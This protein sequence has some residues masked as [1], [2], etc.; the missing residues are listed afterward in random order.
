MT[1]LS[2]AAALAA[3]TLLSF[4]QFPGHTW[5]QSDT[6]IYAPIL[7]HLRN[8]AVLRNEMLV[9]GPH[10]SFTLYDEIAIGL[11][12]LSHL[13]FQQ[14]LALEQI[15]FRGLGILGF[16]LMATA[17]GLARWPALA[18]AAVAALGA[19]IG[20]PSVLLWEYE[21]VPRGFAVPLLFLAAGLAAHRRLL[22][23]AAA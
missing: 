2:I 6:Q 3:I 8:P 11:R 10:V 1:R 7:E 21:P 5:L 22:A 17:A 18:A 14:V 20:G 19:N 4:F 13:E 23:A 16:Y 12:S 9:L 15:C